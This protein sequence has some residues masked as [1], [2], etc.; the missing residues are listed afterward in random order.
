M[1]LPMI[2]T[3]SMV[4]GGQLLSFSL[5]G[6]GTILYNSNPGGVP[7]SINTITISGTGGRVTI[8]QA[9]PIPEP[10]TLLL[11]GSGLAAIGLKARQRKR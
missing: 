10:A 5:T 9:T 11:F 3:G 2:L 8:D 4:A 7:S 6:I 1:T